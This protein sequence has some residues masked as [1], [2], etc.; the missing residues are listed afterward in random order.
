MWIQV[1]QDAIGLSGGMEATSYPL[2]STRYRNP[3][4]ADPPTHGWRESKDLYQQEADSHADHRREPPP[5]YGS[6]GSESATAAAAAGGKRDRRRSCYLR[7]CTELLFETTGARNGPP[8]HWSPPAPQ[9]GHGSLTQ[10]ARRRQ[11]GKLCDSLA[12]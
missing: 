3:T 1:R 8:A 10:L 7:Q 9:S 6:A 5:R 11:R 4:P 2:L 12:G